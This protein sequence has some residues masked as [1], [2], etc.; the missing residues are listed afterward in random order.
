M[1]DDRSI[2]RC[3]LLGR[4]DMYISKELGTS[5]LSAEQLEVVSFSESLLLELLI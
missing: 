1:S 3:P 2:L 5:D 4:F